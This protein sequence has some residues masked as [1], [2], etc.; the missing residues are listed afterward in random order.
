[1]T[2][3]QINELLKIKTGSKYTK[4]SNFW[5]PLCRASIVEVITTGSPM[6]DIIEVKLTKWGDFLLD[7]EVN[8]K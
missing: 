6:Y 2:I 1:M 8:K 4:S 5:A 7:K 3:K